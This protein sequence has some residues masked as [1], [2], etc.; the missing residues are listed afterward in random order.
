MAWFTQDAALPLGAKERSLAADRR[1]PLGEVVSTQCCHLCRTSMA[2]V[3]GPAQ[4][5]DP[6]PGA[7]VEMG[8]GL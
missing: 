8:E 5:L 4:G 6:G 1:G 2:E 3:W 7:G